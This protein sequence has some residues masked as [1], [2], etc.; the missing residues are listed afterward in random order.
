MRKTQGEI[1]LSRRDRYELRTVVSGIGKSDPLLAWQLRPIWRSSFARMRA[2]RS[3]TAAVRQADL[4]SRLHNQDR[5]QAPLSSRKADPVMTTK[6]SSEDSTQETGTES[7]LWNFAD[8]NVKVEPLDLSVV[9]FRVV[10]IDGQAGRVA[11]PVD[12]L[13]SSYLVVSLG[14]LPRKTRLVSVNAVKSVD[15][16]QRKVFLTSTKAQLK[17]ATDSRPRRK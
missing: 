14:W 13:K 11:I 16:K 6:A 3:E 7:K 15:S 5:T 1:V 8:R 4:W 2:N 12:E 10:A 17:Q 9:G